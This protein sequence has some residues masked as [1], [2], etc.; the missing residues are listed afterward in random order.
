MKTVKIITLILVAVV[1]VT[2]I[3]ILTQP[4]GALRA[5]SLPALK[6]M[7]P[8]QALPVYAAA[9]ISHQ[10]YRANTG[11][12]SVAY[13]GCTFGAAFLSALAGVILKLDMLADRDKLRRDLA[14][15]SAAAAALLITL[16]TTGNFE[17]KWRANRLAASAMESAIYKLA[18]PGAD[19]PTIM[20]EIREIHQSQD[21]AVVAR[22]STATKQGP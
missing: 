6:V 8:T 4:F 7:V 17:S 12:W 10:E 18:I 14:A 3:I 13:F 19:L 15:I 22:Q 5:K 1:A 2:L 16:S 9:L 21:Q 11:R 20:T